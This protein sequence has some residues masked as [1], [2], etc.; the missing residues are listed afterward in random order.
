[1]R[2]ITSNTERALSGHSTACTVTHTHT[3]HSHKPLGHFDVDSYRIMTCYGRPSLAPATEELERD[4]GQIHEIMGRQWTQR[5][6]PRTHYC[7]RHFSCS[8]V[9]G[10]R[11]CEVA[12]CLCHRHAWTRAAMACPCMTDR[13]EASC[14]LRI[15]GHGRVVEGRG[16][17][18]DVGLADNLVSLGL[19]C[20]MDE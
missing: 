17:L 11:L 6:P 15:R 10:G 20:R 13:V 2:R 3:H 5:S 1:M 19:F 16:M 4:I 14:W 12:S 8:L 9:R 18:Y 7:C